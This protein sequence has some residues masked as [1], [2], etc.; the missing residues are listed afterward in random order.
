MANWRRYV[1]KDCLY[2]MLRLP[3]KTCFHIVRVEFIYSS[4]DKTETDSI[5]W[6][7]MA[8]FRRHGCDPG[9]RKLCW[10]YRIWNW[11]FTW[12]DLISIFHPH[13]LWPNATTCFQA[14]VVLVGCERFRGSRDSDDVILLPGLVWPTQDLIGASGQNPWGHAL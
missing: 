14:P 6:L 12:F 3:H 4:G 10:S 8:T 7:L 13:S 2:H 11:G 9:D 1:R 5:I